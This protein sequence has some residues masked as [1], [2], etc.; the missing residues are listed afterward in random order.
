MA[1]IT[2]QY[3][4]RNKVVKSILKMIEDSGLFLILRKKNGIDESM[5]DIEKGRVYKCKSVDDM[6]QKVGIKR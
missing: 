1:T 5:D 4:S 2:L 3:D 6:F